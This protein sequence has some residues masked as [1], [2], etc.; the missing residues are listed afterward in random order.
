[1]R[2]I[3]RQPI[4]AIRIIY[5]IFT[6]EPLLGQ[7]TNVFMNRFNCNTLQPGILDNQGKIIWSVWQMIAESRGIKPPR[8]QNRDEMMCL[9]LLPLLFADCGPTGPL[10]AGDHVRK[11]K[12]DGFQRNYKIH[13]PQ[14][15]SPDKPNPVVC[16]FHGTLMD[17]SMMVKFTGMND[18]SEEAG[19][20]TVY[21]D[22]WRGA[23]FHTW[24][25][26][27]L[28]PLLSLGMPDDLQFVDRMLEDLG[29]QVPID[30]K[31]L[32]ACG[33]SSGAM[34]TYR[35]AIERPGRF[36]AVGSV[37]GALPTSLPCPNRATSVIHIQ[38]M[39]DKI[40]RQSGSWGLVGTVLQFRSTVETIRIWLKINVIREEP[41]LVHED[42]EW[43]HWRYGPGVDGSEVDL[44]LI[45]DQG[46]CWPGQIPGL[47][48]LLRW[49][50]C[51][52]ANDLL[53]NFFQRH[54]LKQEPVLF[55]HP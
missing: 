10:G 42:S 7:K 20:I 28:F 12:V 53:W 50:K 38:G 51:V 22:G 34:F 55:N 30:Q 11:I 43:E 25:A 24:N 9:W 31:R 33:F 3:Q 41:N 26:G 52:S 44:V 54:S 46:H 21:P 49:T 48:M 13:I 37:E 5:F 29:Q 47:G 6:I 14:N 23:V 2:E 16:V 40:V 32:Y 45:R 1:M 17:S 36:A 4:K 19:F 18:K 39:S 8:P 35:L 27:A 15:Y